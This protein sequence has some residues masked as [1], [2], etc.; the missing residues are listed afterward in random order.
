MSK[1]KTTA[2]A[3][4]ERIVLTSTLGN[5]DPRVVLQKAALSQDSN[6][7]IEEGLKNDTFAERFGKV[8]SINDTESINRLVV[9]YIY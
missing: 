8:K 9:F 7:V 2:A 6:L 3:I 5:Y 1:L 4:F